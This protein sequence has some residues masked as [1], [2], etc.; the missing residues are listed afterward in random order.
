MEFWEAKEIE[1]ENFKNVARLHPRLFETRSFIDDADFLEKYGIFLEKKKKFP[2]GYLKLWPQDFIVEEITL[3]GEWTTVFPDKFLDKKRNFLPEDPVLYATLVKCGLST[4]EVVNELAKRLGI[5]PLNIK[6]AG[7]KDKHAIT[8][9]LISIKGGD[10]EKINQISASYFFLKNLFSGE[11]ELFLGSL[12]AN[13]FTILIRTSPDFKKE[14]FLKRLKE[15]EKNG[16]YNFFYLQ[17]FGIPR[18]INPYCGLRVLKGDYEGAVKTAICRP[19]GRELFYFQSLRKEIEGLWGNREEIE[20]IIE[21]FPLTFQ[22]EREMIGYLIKNPNDFIGA[23]NQIPRVLQLWLTSFAALL[24][25][26]LLASYL[27]KGEKPPETLPLILD[28]SE[29]SWLPYKEL[30]NQAG[31]YSITFALKNLQPF[32]QIILRKRDQKTREQVKI[33]AQKIIPEGVILQFVLPKGCYATTFLSHLFNLAS[34]NLPKKFSNLPIDTKANLNQP[35][36]EEI[37]NKF[38]DVVSSPSWR[39]LWRIY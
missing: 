32:P 30:L 6:F 36:L 8:S 11:K 9:Q 2:L 10:I 7:V 15:I 24:F 27:K 4:F 28:R 37:L 16:F 34:G 20:G 23:L 29:K 38:T 18:L 21:Q 35:S 3:D 19:G 1:S 22:D 26:K 12:K 13:Q 25:N 14:E 33:I 39:Y 5:E 17:R 31:I